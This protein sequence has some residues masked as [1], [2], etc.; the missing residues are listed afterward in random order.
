MICEKCGCEH[1][2]EYG[3][4][5]FCG[6]ECARSFATWRRR[7][8]I[9]SKVSRT[10]K[11]KSERLYTRIM[12][13]TCRHC[14]KLFVVKHSKRDRIYCSVDCTLEHQAQVEKHAGARLGGQRSSQKRSKVKRS[15]NEIY[16]AKLCSEK[17]EN[18]MTNKA[19]FNGWDA[20]VILEEHKIAILWNGPWHYKKITRKHSLEQV[21]NR[22][23][24]KIKAIEL[25]GF[26][27]Y[28]IKD[29][30]KEN[31]KFVEKEFEI[32]LLWLKSL[33]TRSSIGRTAAL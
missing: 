9:N 5:R 33:W 14:K 19:M 13:L 26:T 15:K 2:G 1:D 18:V 29:M 10:L 6:K 23:T 22:D 12:F 20:D 31:K 30:G 27:P 4:G 3:S 7:E 25:A 16:F 17:F 21:Q 28:I 32:F 8:E 11:T 24:L